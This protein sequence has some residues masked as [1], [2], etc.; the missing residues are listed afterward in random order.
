MNPLFCSSNVLSLFWQLLKSFWSFF[1]FSSLFLIYINCSWSVLVSLLQ[2]DNWLLNETDWSE[3][4]FCSWLKKFLKFSRSLLSWVFSTSKACFSL[5]WVKNSVIWVYMFT[6]ELFLFLRSLTYY[7][8]LF[9][10]LSKIG[11]LKTAASNPSI[12]SFA[13]VKFELHSF[14]WDLKVLSSSWVLWIVDCKLYKF[15]STAP[16]L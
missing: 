5:S 6:N 13:L 12:L 1:T 14:A 3:N 7:S 10:A 11:I 16:Q 8:E 15:Y 4:F 9:K 2:V